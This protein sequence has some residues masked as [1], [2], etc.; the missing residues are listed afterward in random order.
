MTIPGRHLTN[1]NLGA[2]G[3]KSSQEADLL[4]HLSQNLF[5]TLIS[6]HAHPGFQQQG[7][8][9]STTSEPRPL[10]DALLALSSLYLSNKSTYYDQRAVGYYS[11]S[12]HDLRKQVGNKSM[13]GSEDYLLMN[14]VWL[15]I[16]EIWAMRLDRRTGAA[17]HLKGALQILKLRQCSNLD[18]QNTRAV[19]RL[20]AESCL[21]HLANM[22]FFDPS[23]TSL[24]VA[25]VRSILGPLLSKPPF[26]DSS[27]IS[28]C[29]VLVVPAEMYFLVL[30][31]SQLSHCTPLSSENQARGLQ[32]LGALGNLKIQGPFAAL[33]MDSNTKIMY[34]AAYLYVL[35]AKSLLFQ[36]LNPHTLHTHPT[37]QEHVSYAMAILR[38]G[39][40]GEPCK[41]FFCW[42]L[43]ILSSVLEY[44]D[45]IAFVHN[46]LQAAWEISSCGNVLVVLQVFEAISRRR[47]AGENVNTLEFLKNL[48]GDMSTNMIDGIDDRVFEMV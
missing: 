2:Y 13:S 7:T 21:Y 24:R 33:Q 36:L 23:L 20:V 47:L 46:E 22:A 34:D 16:F 44:S 11:K 40:M 10:V 18:T 1:L 9:L 27:S 12:M 28:N 43:L 19:D 17:A 5:P 45:D 39:V 30:E 26:P 25:E 37:I 32:L 38:T 48:Q 15:Y 4:R 14:V 29:P 6:S 3:L 42:P 41:Q 31:V 35:A 8:L